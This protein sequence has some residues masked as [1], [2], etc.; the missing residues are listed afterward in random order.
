MALRINLKSI[1][2]KEQELLA[3]IAWYVTQVRNLLPPNTNIA[4]DGGIATGKDTLGE[5]LAQKLGLI[6][7]NAGDGYRSIAARFHEYADKSIEEREKF[8][9]DLI[10]TNKVALDIVMKDGKIHFLVHG[11][12]M[13]S[14]ID[15]NETA[16]IVSLFSPI[17]GMHT[18]VSERIREFSKQYGVVMAGRDI[19]LYVLPHADFHFE[20]TAPLSVRIKRRYKQLKASGEKINLISAYKQITAREKK[21][22]E[23][24]QEIKNKIP[25][26]FPTPKYHLVI[27]TRNKNEQKVL[28]EVLKF[29]YNIL[30]SQ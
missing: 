6:F 7:I 16:T 11:E 24:I 30:T 27:E 20:L 8:I 5:V 21:D 26:D 15:L 25:K 2:R 3:E 12:D 13:T 18:Y 10:Q 4:V 1:E 14:N 23:M 22:N 19:G 17:E 9:K 29:M 28:L